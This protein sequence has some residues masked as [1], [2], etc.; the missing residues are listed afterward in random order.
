M[1]T[2]SDR[3]TMHCAAG[4]ACSLFRD[5]TASMYWG[6]IFFSPPDV[7]LP[8]H[9]FASPPPPPVRVCVYVSVCVF[10]FVR[11]RVRVRVCV[12][13]CVCACV[14]VCFS[15]SGGNRRVQL[16]FFISLTKVLPP[17]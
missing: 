4:A 3:Q 10:V 15:G 12:C 13:V 16:I 11:V 8:Q 9:H 6:F 14:C 5:S 17:Q 7:G 1:L 2:G